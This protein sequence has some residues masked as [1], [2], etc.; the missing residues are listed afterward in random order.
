MVRR[1]RQHL[2]QGSGGVGCSDSFQYSYDGSGIWNSY[3]P[4]NTIITTG[5]TRVDIRGQRTGCTAGAGCTGTAWAT[6]ASWDI[7]PQPTGPTL[8]AK[9][10]DLATICDGQPVSAT[11]TAG[12]GGVGCSDAFEYSYDGSGIW[13]SYTPGNTIITTGHTRV[14]IRGQRTG[15]TAGCRLYGNCLGNTC[16]VGCKSPTYWTNP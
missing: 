1:Y 7:N 9:I 8:D 14:D 16:I 13:N 12:T 15:C 11:F 4:G 3:T 10:P 6:L 2:L 5:H